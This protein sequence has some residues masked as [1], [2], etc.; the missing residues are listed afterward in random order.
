MKNTSYTNPKVTSEM[1]KA[2]Y[3]TYI[4]GDFKD[5]HTEFANRVILSRME[6]KQVAF[7]IAYLM[8]KNDPAQFSKSEVK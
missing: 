5:K 6:A 8:Y 7:K 1:V 2:Y 3:E 4:I